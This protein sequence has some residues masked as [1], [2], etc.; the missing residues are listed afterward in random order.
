[1]Y[2]SWFHV[3]G[4]YVPIPRAQALRLSPDGTWMAA[5]VQTLGGDPKKYVTSIWRIPVAKDGDAG[6]DGTADRGQAAGGGQA[7]GRDQAG[8][9]DATG[10]WDRAGGRDQAAGRNASPARLTRSAEGEGAPEFLP[11]GSLL[12]VSKRPGPGLGAD[13]DG[14]VG[15]DKPGL[16]LLPAG[17]GEARRIAAPPGGVTGVATARGT[18]TLAFASPG[19]PGA[20]GADED[21][22]RRKAR[23][24]AGGTA[25]LHESGPVRYWDHDLGPD[26]PRLL[27]AEIA[28]A[29][30]P[31]AGWAPGG[32]ADAAAAT[33]A[34]PLPETRDLTPDPGRALDEQAF[35]LAPDGSLIVTGWSAW[36][37]A[38]NRTDKVH[39]IDPATGT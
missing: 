4:E 34:G 3:L 30:A 2:V 12:F 26:S 5:A 17:G 7:A 31:T 29:G 11:D 14:D 24:D 32:S 10:G 21:L 37:E 20:D 35:D 36:D 19:L 22:R 16:W 8:G 6:P 39:V 23:K 13:G 38:G 9:R 1:M 15:Q 33:T 27:A 18:G 28:G 25:I